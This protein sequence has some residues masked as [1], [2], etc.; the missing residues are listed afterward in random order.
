M[1]TLASTWPTPV[2]TDAKDAARGTTSTGVM[3]SGTTLT[4]AIRAWCSRHRQTTGKVGSSGRSKAVLSPEF[5]ETLMG[6]PLRWTLVGDADAFDALE[7]GLFPGKQ[8]RL[9]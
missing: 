4:D 3:H 9:F 8:Q 7:M 5:V 2:T 6:L 1:A